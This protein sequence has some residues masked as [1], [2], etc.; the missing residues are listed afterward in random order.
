MKTFIYDNGGEF[1]HDNSNAF[2]ADKNP[3][4]HTVKIYRKGAQV[5]ELKFT[6]GADGKL[7]DTGFAKPLFLAKYKVIVPVKV[8]G[9]SEKWDALSWKTDAFYGNPIAGF[10]VQ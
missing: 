10:S 8:V 4:E 9:A 2:Y 3:G 5:R 7:M 1:N 6:I